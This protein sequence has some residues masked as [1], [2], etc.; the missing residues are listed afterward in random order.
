MIAFVV[1]VARKHCLPMLLLSIVMKDRDG[2][3]LFMERLNFHRQGVAQQHR[4]RILMRTRRQ[5]QY[6]P[7]LFSMEPLGWRIIAKRLFSGRFVIVAWGG[8]TGGQGRLT[9]TS[10]VN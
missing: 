1:F 4:F 10:L 5:K 9:A 3:N 6:R 8:L 2:W 7:I